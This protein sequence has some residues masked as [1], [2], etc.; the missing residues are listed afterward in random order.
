MC[1]SGHPLLHWRAQAEALLAEAARPE[2]LTDLVE[3]FL[4]PA[5][6]LCRLAHSLGNLA[7]PA[8]AFTT[9]RLAFASARARLVGGRHIQ[10]IRRPRCVPVVRALIQK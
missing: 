4:V 3:R 6:Y 2:N 8:L 9:A 7:K 5:A 10:Y 1:K